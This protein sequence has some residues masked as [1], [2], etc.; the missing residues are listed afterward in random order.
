MT[1]DKRLAF[2]FHACRAFGLTRQDRLEVATVVLD[3]NIDSFKQ[4]G[5]T[6]VARL[7]DAMR[8][9]VTVASIRMERR[10]GTRI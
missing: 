3:R 2:V 6:D 10:A 8:G 7:T 9:A 4:L 1:A 5:P